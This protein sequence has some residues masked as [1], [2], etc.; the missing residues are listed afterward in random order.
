MQFSTVPS[1]SALLCAFC[2]VLALSPLGCATKQP[3][4]GKWM[5][6]LSG[7]QSH[8][9]INADGTGTL[10]VTMLMANFNSPLTWKQED[11]K[12]IVNLDASKLP[13]TV[14]NTRS[15]TWS[16]NDKTLTVSDG[17][18]TETYQREGDASQ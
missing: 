17:G 18:T 4:V 2:I 7:A 12:L 6:N 10:S 8:L 15:W 13:P 5:M 9:T 14:P 11:Q 3:F 16:V 1:R